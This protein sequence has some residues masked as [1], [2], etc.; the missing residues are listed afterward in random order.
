M[1][2]FLH[3]FALTPIEVAP[4]QELA[5][6]AGTALSLLVGENLVLCEKARDVLQPR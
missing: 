3:R 2:D 1:G 5:A 6:E 4:A